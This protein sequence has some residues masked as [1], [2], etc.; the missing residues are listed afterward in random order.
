MEHHLQTIMQVA[1]GLPAQT[2]FH[3]ALI[4]LLSICDLE[5]HEL[6]AQ[7][8]QLAAAT[9]E[10]H[11]LMDRLAEDVTSANEDETKRVM[12]NI[13]LSS[14]LSQALEAE[15]FQLK[16]VQVLSEQDSFRKVLT[17]NPF[18]GYLLSN[19]YEI[20][21]KLES[22]TSVAGYSALPALP[23][24]SAV[25]QDHLFR[26]FISSP[27]DVVDE[28]GLAK[29]TIAEFAQ[30]YQPSVQLEAVAWDVPGYRTPMPAALT[31][32]Q[33][34]DL[35]LPKPSECDVVVVIFWSRLGTPLDPEK[36]PP[37]P[38]RAPYLSGTEWE[39]D[40]AM[41]ASL[42]LGRPDVLVYRR[43]DE[44]AFRASD[45]HLEEKV[46]QYKR[47]NAF[48]ERFHNPDGSYKY[49]YSVY[50]TPSEFQRLLDLDL[51]ILL[52]K[53]FGH[54]RGVSSSETNSTKTLWIGSPFRGLRP[55]EQEHAEIFFG[56]GR[57]VDALLVVLDQVNTRVV[58]VVGASGSGKSSLVKAGLIP[59]LKQNAIERNE[60]WHVIVHTPDQQGTGN[61]FI[62][63]I[64]AIGVDSREAPIEDLEASS[65][66]D[67]G[68]YGLIV[69][70]L[71]NSLQ[72]QTL[73][74]VDQFE[75]LFTLIKTKYQQAYIELLKKI[76]STK[77]LRVLITLR[78]DF[79]DKCM[80]VPTLADM[81]QG[82]LYHLLPPTRSALYE[83]I[84]KPAER[85]GIT[86]EGNLAWD[87]LEDAGA[88]PG[89]LPLLSYTL[90]ELYR[91]CEDTRHF[92]YEAY[93][94]LGGVEGAIGNRA[95][96][97]YS[98][99]DL[100]ARNALPIVFQDLVRVEIE[101]EP[102][103]KRTPLNSVVRG[104]ST[105]RLVDA[106]VSERLLVLSQGTHGGAVLE[107]AHEALFRNWPAL[108]DWIA[109]AKGDLY[110]LEQVRQASFAWL[111]SQKNPSY[112]W[113]DERLKP[114]HEMIRRLSPH[115]SEMEQEFIKPEAS[116][117]IQELNNEALTHQRRK[118]IGDRLEVIGDPR[119]GIGAI[120]GLPDLVWCKVLPGKVSVS[121]ADGEKV[122]FDVTPFWIAKYPVTFLQFEMFMSAQNGFTNAEWWTGLAKRY[123][124]PGNQ[125][126]KYRNYPRETVSWYEAVA[127]CRWLTYELKRKGRVEGIVQGDWEIRLPTEW[128]WQLAATGG[129]D[130]YVYPW[131]ETWN[132]NNAFVSDTGLSSG[133]AVGLY[134][135]NTSPTGVMDMCGGVWEWCLNTFAKMSPVRL[136]GNAT[137]AFRGGSFTYDS[138]SAKS[139]FRFHADPLSRRYDLG[140]RVSLHSTSFPRA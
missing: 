43:K 19:Q 41:E 136:E 44:L 138:E 36:H 27:G 107:V 11:L 101:G 32:Q 81:I 28:R 54:G 55:F 117:L 22:L 139:T 73:F 135:L 9:S 84:R 47:L 111:H 34:I 82:G 88:Q 15:E 57:D 76:A 64:A 137:R 115:L 109:E 77:D 62:S 74:V 69:Q 35:G 66:T 89:T 97:I 119:P 100:T 17:D 31:P 68:N 108:R 123:S 102:T 98:R 37:R 33:A 70:D 50:H 1:S 6:L 75:E 26:V 49:S 51:N 134:P 131:G 13:A 14:G 127:F 59:R 93:R 128:E 113:P 122:Q 83:I 61:P 103:R 72:K 114:A 5:E 21:P 133:M 3:I 24:A 118:E 94:S 92:T 104:D 42:S 71:V 25:D 65:Y 87:V 63:L 29:A 10:F 4:A 112:L 91:L 130:E 56:R 78:A 116:R 120:D 96:E 2:Q 7:R 23:L 140:F 58:T 52:R 30:T 60:E 38:G 106:L 125:R 124:E 79:Y 46:T 12:L 53:R 85:V 95:N 18:L 45:P 121:E 40:D 99:L 129:R 110:I 48:F 132:P 86:F 8:P 105:R 90:D 16:L 67:V 39:F 80:G 126:Y 20:Y